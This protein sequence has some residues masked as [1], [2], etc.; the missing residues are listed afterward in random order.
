MFTFCPCSHLNIFLRRFLEKQMLELR[1]EDATFL[2][3]YKDINE[4]LKN[5][6]N[7]NENAQN[8]HNDYL[9][10]IEKE[11][12]DLNNLNNLFRKELDKLSNQVHLLEKKHVRHS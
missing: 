6:M 10:R 11:N 3:D 5:K 2:S 1:Y 8:S 4:P 12:E 7:Q 9:R